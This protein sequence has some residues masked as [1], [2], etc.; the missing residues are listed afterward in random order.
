MTL[1]DSLEHDSFVAD[2]VV[3]GFCL[4]CLYGRLR[5]SDGMLLYDLRLDMEPGGAD[6][7]VEGLQGPGKTSTSKERRTILLPVA[8]PAKG[9]LKESV[10]GKTYIDL[11]ESEGLLSNGKVVKK[12]VMV[13]PAGGGRVV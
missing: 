11:L 5:H 8:A 13:A 2:R 10:W 3:S 6:G 7:F 4:M 9:L 1:E 12:S